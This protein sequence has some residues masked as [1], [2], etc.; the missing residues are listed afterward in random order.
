MKVPQIILS[1]STIRDTSMWHFYLLIAGWASVYTAMNVAVVLFLNDALGN[2]FLA[3]LALAIG[4][5]FALCFDGVF[6]FFQGKFSSRSLF[7]WSIVGMILAVLLFL[8]SASSLSVYLAAILFRVSFDLCDITA[9]AYVLKRSRAEEYGQNLSYKQLAQGIGLIGGFLISAMLIWTAEIIDLT[10]KSITSKTGELV[11]ADLNAEFIS[12][13]LLVKVFLLAL[14]VVMWVMAYL[15]FDRETQVIDRQ[16]LKTTFGEIREH[17]VRQFKTK[18]VRLKAVLPFTKTA[19]PQSSDPAG[20]SPATRVDTRALFGELTSAISDLALVGKHR[21]LDL[22]LIWTIGV[23]CIFSYWDTFLG[24]YMPIYLTKV[25]SQQEGFLR[26]VPGSILM[27][28]LILPVLALLPLAAKWGDR[29]GRQPLILI[30]LVMTIMATLGIGILRPKEITILLAC[31][32][33]ITFGY[34]FVMSAIRANTAIKMNQFLLSAK[35][36]MLIDTNKSA[37]SILLIDNIGNIVG[38]LVG[39]ALI[40]LLK[41]NGFFFVFGLM[42]LVVLAVT[43]WKYRRIFG[44]QGGAQPLTTTG[45]LAIAPM[46]AS[47][48]ELPAPVQAPR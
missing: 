7:L 34:L 14:L 30:G 38:T 32:F 36:G 46:T 12:A 40:E 47:L 19:S 41:F 1:H 39:G 6:S 5:V 4:S 11:K 10:T 25:L 37:G 20:I 31:G 27:F 3:G 28:I 29:H 42:L 8:V 43:I 9:T 15:L 44:N 17:S 45:E 24:T 48:P 23:S 22:P 2:L 18:I 16:A 13:L 21:P 33:G 26:M 35:P